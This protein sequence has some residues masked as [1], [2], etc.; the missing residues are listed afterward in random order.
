MKKIGAFM[1]FSDLRLDEGPVFKM[2]DRFLAKRA[3]DNPLTNQELAQMRAN[4]AKG[5][6]SKAAD[7]R[8]KAIY[9]HRQALK[10]A[11]P[12][13]QISPEELQQ[14]D[15]VAVGV[16]HSLKTKPDIKDVKGF[17]LSI[18]KPGMTEQ[19]LLKQALAKFSAGA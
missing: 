7:E 8:L 12:R 19:E 9:A 1:K 5:I 2:V 18:Y 3:R 13:P 17:L 4:A 14:L 16:F 15:D 6:I 11:S 10:T